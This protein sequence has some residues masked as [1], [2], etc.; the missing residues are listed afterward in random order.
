MNISCYCT[1]LQLAIVVIVTHEP[2]CA[3]VEISV[4][5]PIEYDGL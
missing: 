4:D 1:R 3:Q 2:L 5:I